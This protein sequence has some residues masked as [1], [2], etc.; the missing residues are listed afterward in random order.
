MNALRNHCACTSK[1]NQYSRMKLEQSFAHST[2]RHAVQQP[3]F[4]R[5]KT[6]E[7]D[8]RQ[9]SWDRGALEIFRF[10]GFVL[11]EGLDSD[12]EASKA[13]E[14]AEDEEGEED[15]I[16]EGT[17]TE[18]KGCGGWGHAKRDLCMPR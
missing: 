10:S 4:V 5:P 13:R 7:G 8:N 3:A 1:E 16:K 12:I 11:W 2:E 17:E 18:R 14:T 9:R 6:H 15:G